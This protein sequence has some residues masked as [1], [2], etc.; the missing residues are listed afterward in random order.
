MKSYEVEKKC[1]GVFSGKSSQPTGEGGEILRPLLTI[2]LRS[3]FRLM[4]D[5]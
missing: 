3:F 4:R 1:L 2:L 5:F